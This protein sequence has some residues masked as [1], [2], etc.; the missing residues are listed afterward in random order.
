[1]LQG[2]RAFDGRVEEG[3]AQRGREVVSRAMS[4]LCAGY[5]EMETRGEVLPV[6]EK[7]SELLVASD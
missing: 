4:E 1:M 6:L 5:F 7:V 3:D 2:L